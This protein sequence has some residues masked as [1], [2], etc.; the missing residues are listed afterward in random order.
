MVAASSC[1]GVGD[2]R[3]SHMPMGSAPHRHSTLLRLSY[4]QGASILRDVKIIRLL[5]F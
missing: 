5:T 3:L 2:R 1:V 4:V